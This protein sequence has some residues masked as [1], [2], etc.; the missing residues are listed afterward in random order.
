MSCT[1]PLI[2]SGGPVPDYAGVS[3]ESLDCLINCGSGS[4]GYSSLAVLPRCTD[5]SNAVD[6]TVGQRSD[7]VLLE[8]GDDFTVA[9][10]G[11]D[12]RPLETNSAAKWFIA[13]RINLQRRT[14]NGRISN[15]PVATM[16]SPINI[17]R[18][19]PTVINVPIGDADGD[20]RR[21]R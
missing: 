19:Q 21:C 9:Y 2:A 7:T 12:W 14:D 3:G 16:M 6:T 8:I 4:T 20:N 5:F 17:P 10:R 1:N 18:N 15:A 11:G 13:S